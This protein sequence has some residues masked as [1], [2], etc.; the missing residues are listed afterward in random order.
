[1]TSGETPIEGVTVTTAPA[2]ASVTTAADGRF[3]IASVPVGVYRVF[4]TK[5][6]FEPAAVEGVSVAGGVET[7]VTVLLAP[8]LRGRI[9]GVVRFSSGAPAPN[10]PVSTDRHGARTMTGVDGR[11]ELEVPSTT[12][13]VVAA[14]MNETYETGTAH[15]VTVPRGGEAVADIVLRP[16]PIGSSAYIGSSACAEC[17]PGQYNRWSSTLHNNSIRYVDDPVPSLGGS[18]IS[19]WSGTISLARAPGVNYQVE[20]AIE[21]GTYRATLIDVA[22]GRRTYTV[23][24]THGGGSGW[25]QRY[26]VRIG[27]LFY[28]LPIQWNEPTRQWVAYN[29]QYWF[30]PDGTPRDPLPSDSYEQ[31]CI[32]CH[33]TG[34]K[35]AH[36][37]SNV[38]TGVRFVE[39]NIGCEACHGPGSTHALTRNAGDI[40]NPRRLITR[41]AGVFDL[42][43]NLVDSAA[44]DGYLRANEV[45]G[46]CHHRGESNAASD[47]RNAFATGTHEYPYLHARGEDG[48]YRPGEPLSWYFRDRTGRWGDTRYDHV[49][50][51]RQHHQQW[52]DL[53]EAVR[54][55]RS[56]DNHARNPFYLVACFDCHSPHGSALPYQLRQTANE[57]TLCLSCHAGHGPFAPAPGSTVEAAALAHSRHFAYDPGGSGQARCTGCHM[58]RT[59]KSAVDRDISSH[60]FS[61]IVPQESRDMAGT[62]RV[63]NSCDN[64][65]RNDADFGV[66]RWEVF[67][68]PRS[69]V[70]P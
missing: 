68:G 46:Q 4:A 22:G 63:P 50:S 57:N 31:D 36:D 44:Y 59:A 17:H 33:S 25:K 70:A 2:T 9:R 29:P 66:L 43:G 3:R 27:G 7:E 62:P 52:G 54:D 26:H 11:Y 14:P 23:L 34:L 49:S 6:G 37:A 41:T 69:P 61:I 40:L 18:V 30:N 5:D 1:M 20:L 60:T 19:D 24:R 12:Y 55:P 15:E 32:G 45:C 21:G 10:V 65:H 8:R 58:P 42:Q 13:T 38:T 53:L 67:F 16:R 51:S 47:F 28:L 35:V 48:A 39:G 56:P 64:C